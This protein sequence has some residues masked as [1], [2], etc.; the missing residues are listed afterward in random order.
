[1]QITTLP[2]RLVQVCEYATGDEAEA[3]GERLVSDGLEPQVKA[4]APRRAYVG[5]FVPESQLERA[6]EVLNLSVGPPPT[7]MEKP[8]HPCPKCGAG[9]PEWLG[10]WKALLLV[11][12]GVFLVAVAAFRSAWLPGAWLVAILGFVG[13]VVFLPEFQCRQCRWRWTADRADR[14]P[15]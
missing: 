2:E 5:L 15:N 1:M 13:G 11:S 3:A 10:K 4:S 7:S 14:L 6:R 9:D 12:C 8:L